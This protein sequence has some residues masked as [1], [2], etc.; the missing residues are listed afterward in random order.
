MS[1]LE[2]EVDEDI[3][4]NKIVKYEND[5]IK[6]QLFYTIYHN[7]LHVI[8]AQH[9]KRAK[10]TELLF[11]KEKTVVPNKRLTDPTLFPLKL[12]GNETDWKLELSFDQ[13]TKDFVL[14]IN[15]YTFLLLPYQAEA[16]PQ[17]P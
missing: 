2:P 15:G 12:R 6:Q 5:K 16:I 7:E 17:G 9:H 3:Y 8:T 1:T 14:E 11:D 13:E 10:R 4:H